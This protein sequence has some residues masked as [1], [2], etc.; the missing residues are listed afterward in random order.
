MFTKEDYVSLETAKLLKEKGFDEPVL[1]QYS[2]AG[3][4]W[5]CSEPENFND[6]K[7]CFS[8]PTL[9]EAQKWLREKEGIA[10]NIYNKLTTY[11]VSWSYEYNKIDT[12]I[13]VNDRKGKSTIYYS[14]QQALDAGI[15]EALKLI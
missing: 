7:D 12:C 6:S 1:A 2:K 3:N 11:G 15:K 14:Y 10:V 9:Y 5:T 8:R 13:S 4:V